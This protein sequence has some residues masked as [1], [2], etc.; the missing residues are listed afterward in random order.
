MTQEAGKVL[1]W[2]HI[3]HRQ[4][5]GGGPIHRTIAG[6]LHEDRPEDDARVEVLGDFRYWYTVEPVGIP[7]GGGER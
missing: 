7:Q 6:S 4:R 5:V 3:K 2:M 1:G